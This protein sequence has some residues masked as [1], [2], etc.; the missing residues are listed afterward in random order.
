M[1][2]ARTKGGKDVQAVLGRSKPDITTAVYMQEIDES[3]TRTLD[4][5]CAQLTARPKLAAV[6]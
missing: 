3:V 6:S 4:A 1:N 2:L 5:V